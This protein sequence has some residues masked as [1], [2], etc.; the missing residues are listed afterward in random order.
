[1]PNTRRR[2]GILAA[3]GSL[4]VAAALLIGGP[5][6]QSAISAS[7]VD[8]EQDRRLAALEVEV[9]RINGP[10]QFPPATETPEPTPDPTPTEPEPTPTEP[11]PTPTDEPE[12]PEEPAGWDLV[13]ETD[14]TSNDGWRVYNNQT[15]GNDNSVNVAKNAV[16]GPDGLTLLGKREASNGRPFTSAEIVGDNVAKL[17]VP[18][19]F[20]AEVVGTF[21]DEA[22]IWPCLLWYRPD[23]AS[24][25]EIDV[26]EWMGGMWTGTQKRV[27]ITMHN[28][29][30]STQD[31]AKAPMIL[32]NHSWYDPNVEHTYTIEKVPGSITVWVDGREVAKFTS[33]VKPWWNRIMENESRTWYPRITLQIG[34][35]ATTKVVPNPAASFRQTEVNVTSYKVWEQK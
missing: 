22:G 6:P 8:A 11:E 4:V 12:E 21:K 5:A 13:Y 31:S 19:Y 1:M 34:Q 35:G 25:G 24:D 3:L 9:D 18:N 14:F 30:G 27:A 7:D 15:Q 10:G 17:V 26:M 28:E 16:F 33:S 23:N 20:R 32:R 2:T 29:Y